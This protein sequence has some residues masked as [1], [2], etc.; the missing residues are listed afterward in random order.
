MRFASSMMRGMLPMESPICVPILPAG[1]KGI[2]ERIRWRVAHLR[3]LR[4]Q[5]E[6]RFQR[7]KY[8]E[9]ER[10]EGSLDESAKVRGIQH[11]HCG[12]RMRSMSIPLIL[13]NA[14]WICILPDR[15]PRIPRPARIERERGFEPP[16]VR[17]RMMM[18]RSFVLGSEVLR[19]GL[20]RCGVTTM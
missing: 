4:V 11:L 3:A 15:L 8:E 2:R 17:V 6:C 5:S 10:E 16:A 20:L 18:Q 12:M 13:R 7:E 9:P 19:K 14:P 1:T